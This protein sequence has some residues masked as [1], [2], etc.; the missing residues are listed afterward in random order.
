MF[1]IM[2]FTPLN[3]PVLKFLFCREDHG[4]GSLD[5]CFLCTVFVFLRIMFPVFKQSVLVDEV[6]STLRLFFS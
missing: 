6:A 5:L 4:K 2:D 3:K 1:K